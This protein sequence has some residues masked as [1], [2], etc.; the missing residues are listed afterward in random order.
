MVSGYNAVVPAVPF[1]R[2]LQS[3][4]PVLSQVNTRREQKCGLLIFFTFFLPDH[5]LSQCS[6]LHGPS[7]D[8]LYPHARESQERKPEQNSLKASDTVVGCVLLF[9]SHTPTLTGA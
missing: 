8:L 3:F 1:C 9:F 7:F 5:L 2:R 6:Y 4:H